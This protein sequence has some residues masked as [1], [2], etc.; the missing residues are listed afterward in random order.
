MPS[1]INKGL[2]GFIGAC[3]IV[4]SSWA[5]DSISSIYLVRHAE[6]LSTKPDPAL[7]A[8]GI[9]RAE[10]LSKQLSMVSFKQVF[11]TQYKRT[12]G[13][14]MPLAESNNIE[15]AFYDPKRL[16]QMV[17]RVEKLSGN[18][19]IVGH[20]NTTAVLAG[21]FVNQ[22]LKAFDESIYDRLYQVTIINGVSQLQ[23]LQQNFVCSDE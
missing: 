1:L 8:C 16:P 22:E 20:S 14:A 7:T 19:L 17:D 23:I 13:T 4:S 11:S 12:I 2:G 3:L 5:A 18:T 21:L 15:I 6:K 10:A 9:A